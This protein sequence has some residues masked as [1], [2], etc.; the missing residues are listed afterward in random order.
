MG[1]EGNFSRLSDEDLAPSAILACDSDIYT[2]CDN[3]RNS[4]DANEHT[5]LEQRNQ[6]LL[7]WYILIPLVLFISVLFPL[8]LLQPFRLAP[9]PP[10]FPL[11]ICRVP[12]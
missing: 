4:V 7:L 10:V 2:G 3:I 6:H 11:I 12:L 1:P 9:L 8:P 5:A